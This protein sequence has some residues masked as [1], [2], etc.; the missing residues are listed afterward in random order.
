[1]AKNQSKNPYRIE[2][3]ETAHRLDMQTRKLWENHKN[4]T[5][6]KNQ[7]AFGYKVMDVLD[8]VEGAL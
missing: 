5:F 2:N 4:F 8:V 7:R 1:Y 6:V 3:W